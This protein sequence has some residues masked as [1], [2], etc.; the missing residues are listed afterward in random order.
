M[1]FSKLAT[2]VL[3]AVSLASSSFAGTLTEPV[4]ETV[5]PAPEAASSGGIIVPLLLLVGV[6]L[7][8]SGGDSDSRDRVKQPCC[9]T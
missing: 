6:A 9:P 5:A 8:I 3:I 7:L 2:T 4:I 1:T